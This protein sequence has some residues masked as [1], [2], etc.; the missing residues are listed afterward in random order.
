MSMDQIS[1]LGNVVVILQ[2]IIVSGIPHFV[3]CLGS[4]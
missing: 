2:N 4:L 1:I 3:S